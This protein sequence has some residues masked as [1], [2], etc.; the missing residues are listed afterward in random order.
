[1]SDKIVRKWRGAVPVS[2]PMLFKLYPLHCKTISSI[3]HQISSAFFVSAICSFLHC[4]GSL[5]NRS[6][7]VSDVKV[8]CFIGWLLTKSFIVSVGKYL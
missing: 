7:G 2:E 5:F 3:L 1:M 6:L 4:Q 8:I